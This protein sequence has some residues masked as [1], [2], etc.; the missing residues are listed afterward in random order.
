MALKSNNK[1]TTEQRSFDF[2]QDEHHK[3]KATSSSTKVT[4]LTTGCVEVHRPQNDR[5]N[6]WSHFISFQMKKHAC[7]KLQFWV[8]QRLTAR[9]APR[10]FR[11]NQIKSWWQTHAA[12]RTKASTKIEG[13]FRSFR[14]RKHIRIVATFFRKQGLHARRRILET[15]SAT[16]IQVLLRYFFRRKQY[17]A[18][19]KYL[20]QIMLSKN[21]EISFLSHVANLFSAS[22]TKLPASDAYMLCNLFSEQIE[23]LPVSTS[24]LSISAEQVVVLAVIL[25]VRPPAVVV[26][27]GRA[28]STLVG[29]MTESDVQSLCSE[30][31]AALSHSEEDS[32]VKQNEEDN[33]V[34]P[35]KLTPPTT[36]STLNILTVSPSTSTSDGKKEKRKQSKITAERCRLTSF[37]VHAV[38]ASAT[39]RGTLSPKLLS[40]LMKVLDVV[41]ELQQSLENPDDAAILNGAVVQK[42]GQEQLTVPSSSLSPSFAATIRWSSDNFIKE[43]IIH[44]VLV[45]DD[46]KIKGNDH[47][48]PTRLG[49]LCR[50]K[51]V[52]DKAVGEYSIGW[53]N[54]PEYE[55]RSSC[56]LFSDIKSFQY[57]DFVF[58]KKVKGVDFIEVAADTT[59]A[60]KYIPVGERRFLPTFDKAATKQYLVATDG[61]SIGEHCTAVYC[62]SDGTSSGHDYSAF[63][64]NKSTITQFN[65]EVKVVYSVVYSDGE[66]EKTLSAVDEKGRLRLK[67]RN[68]PLFDK[69]VSKSDMKDVPKDNIISRQ[70]EMEKLEAWVNEK[71]KYIRY[72][73]IVQMVD[74]DFLSII[75][76]SF[77]KWYPLYTTNETN[78]ELCDGLLKIYSKMLTPMPLYPDVD[79]AMKIAVKTFPSMAWVVLEKL[80]IKEDTTDITTDMLKMVCQLLEYQFQRDIQDNKMAT[81]SRVKTVMNVVRNHVDSRSVQNHGAQVLY[82]LARSSPTAK[83]IVVEGGGIAF[84]EELNPSCETVIN[85]TKYMLSQNARGLAMNLVAK[86]D[87][88]MMP[89][90]ESLESKTAAETK[91]SETKTEDASTKVSALRQE[92]YKASKG[93]EKE[94]LWTVF[95][96]AKAKLQ[97]AEDMKSTMVETK[98]AGTKTI[99]SKVTTNIPVQPKVDIKQTESGSGVIITIIQLGEIK[100][101]E[102]DLEEKKNIISIN[103]TLKT[104]LAPVSFDIELND[105]VKGNVVQEQIKAQYIKEKNKLQIELTDVV[106]RSKKK[107]Q[108]Y[109]EILMETLKQ[110]ISQHVPDSVSKKD[111]SRYACSEC[112][113]SQLPCDACSA[114]FAKMD[115]EHKRTVWS[116][117]STDCLQTLLNEKVADNNVAQVVEMLAY[118]GEEQERKIVGGVAISAKGADVLLTA[119]LPRVKYSHNSVSF[120]DEKREIKVKAMILLD[121]IESN[122]SFNLQLDDLLS[123]KDF[124]SDQLHVEENENGYLQLRLSGVNLKSSLQA[125]VFKA[126]WI[127]QL[128]ELGIFGEWEEILDPKSGKTFYYNSVTKQSE[129]DMPMSPTKL[130]SL[131]KQL[132]PPPPPPCKDKNGFKVGMRCKCRWN[133]MRYKLYACKITK[134]TRNA[135]PELNTYSVL[136][137]DGDT[138]DNVEL[139]RM[140]HEKKNDEGFSVAVGKGSCSKRYYCGRKLGRA[141]I[142]GSDGQCGPDDGPPCKS[143]KRVGTNSSN[144]KANEATSATEPPKPPSGPP[145]QRHLLPLPETKNSNNFKNDDINDRIDDTEN[146]NIEEKKN[147]ADEC[148]TNDLLLADDK[149]TTLSTLRTNVVISGLKAVEEMCGV[150]VADLTIAGE[151]SNIDECMAAHNMQCFVQCKGWQPVI[152]IL[153]ESDNCGI[154]SELDVDIVLSLLT[155]LTRMCSTP[156]IENSARILLRDE[157]VQRNVW[158]K[159]VRNF[160]L[161]LYP[162]LAVQ[163][164]QLQDVFDVFT[165]K[166]LLPFKYPIGRTIVGLLSSS[167]NTQTFN[168]TLS[169]LANSSKDQSS[170]LRAL[171][172]MVTKVLFDKHDSNSTPSLLVS[173]HRVQFG[174]DKLAWLRAETLVLPW[175]DAMRTVVNAIRRVSPSIA[176]AKAARG[177]LQ[178]F[179]APSVHM[180]QSGVLTLQDKDKVWSECVHNNTHTEMSMQTM[181]KQILRRRAPEHRQMNKEKRIKEQH[182]RACDLARTQNVEK[183]ISELGLDSHY[184]NNTP[185][186]SKKL[187]PRD[188]IGQLLAREEAWVGA[189][190]PKAFVR[191][192]IDDVIGRLHL[193]EDPCVRHVFFQGNSGTGKATAADYVARWF[194]LIHDQNKTVPKALWCK[195]GELV[196]LQKWKEDYSDGTL[197]L[198]DTGKITSVDSDTVQVRGKS[199][200]VEDLGLPNVETF[201]ECHSMSDLDA[202]LDS[203]IPGRERTLYYRLQG[204]GGG[205]ARAAMV[206]ERAQVKKCHII[207]GGSAAACASFIGGNFYFLR[208]EP[209][210]LDMPVMSTSELARISLQVIERRGYKLSTAKTGSTSLSGQLKAMVHIVAQKYSTADIVKRNAYLVSDCVE[211]AVSRKNR[212]LRDQIQNHGRSTSVVALPYLLEPCDFD[213]KTISLE[214][215]QKKRELIDAKIEASIGWGDKVRELLWFYFRM[216]VCLEC[217]CTDREF[218]FFLFVFL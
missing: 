4:K 83:G 212:R 121:G 23:T 17:L 177:L 22:S 173:D 68:V 176:N 153:V 201:I 206:L 55:D 132:L 208:H 1:E 115:L 87:S 29:R 84:L 195:V 130:T 20:C 180:Y 45:K 128:K 56:S 49:P 126:S 91:T 37:M 90:T 11:A 98:M 34:E 151:K 166:S 89:V 61:F 217:M 165:N 28:L 70:S 215:R 170:C 174:N 184:N 192:Y 86:K 211:L 76:T 96:T 124:V 185:P 116:T 155:F 123:G 80:C 204:G 139:K 134:I 10:V 14:T 143:C 113:D 119:Y 120:S 8:R 63:L 39:V 43:S 159:L 100:R 191:G 152:S 179:F 16:K 74:L 36:L 102:V 210:V 26:S 30:L 193:Q 59:G 127:K 171:T 169:S 42:P 58:G 25:F 40:T 207:F 122:S 92:W 138:N 111:N 32:N 108:Q 67:N 198:G 190:S 31:A 46:V 203:V 82:L 117:M 51:V 3:S 150:M 75:E 158:S 149:N 136:F 125:E 7:I 2:K 118:I 24:S 181:I 199:Y 33:N 66:I 69:G 209:R 131:P 168:S 101:M 71:N 19:K 72:G 57:T 53:R 106:L 112:K 6:K 162:T 18:R 5:S 144:K 64:L 213:V 157:F 50:Y 107:Q 85:A 95:Q 77:Q 129:W 35:A 178:V 218:Y 94:R 104:S 197:K 188:I 65:G 140:E 21:H 167:I 97:E 47:E 137:D 172:L 164:D 38:C 202:A 62:G 194:T 73:N 9:R 145:Q 196:E 187:V 186:A 79:C 103:A 147:G 183:L 205:G 48:D 142:P 154:A 175:K 163:L 44:K 52:K 60:N 146:D 160:P 88:M 133:E 156:K 135:N 216:I 78:K 99:S 141:A 81:R 214:E 182:D 200:Q 54:S 189:E 27:V 12:R 13:F 148:K 41:H 93:K 161:S 105:I 114:F 110:I 15:C 109:K